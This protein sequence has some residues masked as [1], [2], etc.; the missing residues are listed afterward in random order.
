MPRG[1]IFIF[2]FFLVGFGS[3]RALILSA[4]G[5]SIDRVQVRFSPEID[6]VSL[7]S[8]APREMRE[9]NPSASM[10]VFFFEEKERYSARCGVCHTF[11]SFLETLTLVGGK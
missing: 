8:L 10:G 2:R 6:E 5:I 9:E 1:L 4:M 7:V 11:G 3:K